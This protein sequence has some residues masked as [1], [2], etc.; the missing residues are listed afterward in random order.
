VSRA[1]VSAEVF[2][3]GNG[4]CTVFLRASEGGDKENALLDARW[5][6]AQSASEQGLIPY[7]QPVGTRRGFPIFCD[8]S[9]RLAA[10]RCERQ[11]TTPHEGCVFGEIIRREI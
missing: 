5:A 9:G 11:E 2:P 4:G 6:L 10:L 3:H 7:R 1:V 8:E